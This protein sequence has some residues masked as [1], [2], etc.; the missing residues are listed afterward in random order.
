MPNIYSYDVRKAD[1]SNVS[2]EQF[3]GKVLLIVNVASRCGFTSQY[4]G[5][6]Q[7]HDKYAE[8]GLVI[9]AFPCNQFGNQEPG[10]DQEVQSFCSLK[11]N[12]TFDVLA[13]VDV[14][15]PDTIPL[16]GYL[17]NQAPGLLGLQG[18]K[19]NFT[20]FLVDRQGQVVKRYFSFSTPA[21]IEAEIQKALADHGSR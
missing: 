10:S 5:L 16:Y 7:L 1:G 18:I 15:G 19:W 9:L 4:A 8:Q 13:K 3:R 17:K 12:V 11:Y 6:Q 20:K 14:N 2:L 21:S